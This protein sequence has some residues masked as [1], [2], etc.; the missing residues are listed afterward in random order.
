M[1][2]WKAV[3]LEPAYNLQS[4]TVAPY[5]VV[6]MNR[7]TCLDPKVRQ[8]FLWASFLKQVTPNF[9]HLRVRF[10]VLFRAFLGSVGSGCAS[11]ALGPRPR[12]EFYLT[13]ARI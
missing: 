4:C 9:E 6:S 8:F 2:G 13:A 5:N 10:A 12:D 1:F 3:E 11:V 7:G